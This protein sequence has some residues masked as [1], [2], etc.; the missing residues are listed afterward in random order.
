ML[1]FGLQPPSMRPLHVSLRTT[2]KRL[3][4]LLPD[5]YGMSP[6]THLLCF[7][8][9]RFSSFDMFGYR[10]DCHSEHVSLSS[11]TVFTTLRVLLSLRTDF[12]ACSI[13][14]SRLSSIEFQPPLNHGCTVA[15]IL[16]EPLPAPA[17]ATSAADFHSCRRHPSYHKPPPIQPHRHIWTTYP[18]SPHSPYSPHAPVHTLTTAYAVTTDSTITARVPTA[19]TS[20]LQSHHQAHLSKT[21]HCQELPPPTTTYPVSQ[22]TH[23]RLL[24]PN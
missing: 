4:R 20:Q 16:L 1:I 19:T 13:N 6:A 9:F 7:S 23:P 5:L 2:K 3:R 10:L 18:C 24:A 12:S 15:T 21:V 14:H 17:A 11:H 8:D 22:A